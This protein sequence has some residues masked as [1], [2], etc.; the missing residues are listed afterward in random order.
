MPLPI[1]G[2]SRPDSPLELEKVGDLSFEKP[3]LNRFKCL[4][5]ALK[6]G[7]VG[8]SMPAVLNGANEIA[9]DAFLKG[10]IGFLDIPKLIEQTMDAHEPHPIDRIDSVIVADNW[11]REKALA[12]LMTY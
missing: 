1:P 2:T 6:A 8:E 9:V 3:D 12:I 4:A 7:S 5:L 11:A 10:K